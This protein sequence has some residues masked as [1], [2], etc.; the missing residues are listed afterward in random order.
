MNNQLI[1]IMQQQGFESKNALAEKCNFCGEIASATWNC[2]A[3]ES[4]IGV[5]RTCANTFLMKLAAD[6]AVA[7]NQAHSEKACRAFWIEA[8]S[9]FF[10]SLFIHYARME[11]WRE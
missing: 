5:C 3:T 9:I 4:Q 11:G 2:S 1:K 6:A 8:E 10:K 7:P